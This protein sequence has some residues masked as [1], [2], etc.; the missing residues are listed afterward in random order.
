[1]LTAYND[2]FNN[3]HKGSEEWPGQGL[4]L[5]PAVTCYKMVGRLHDGRNLRI[6]FTPPRSTS[7]FPASA[8]GKRPPKLSLS[9]PGWQPPQ[10]VRGSGFPPPPGQICFRG[11]APL[12]LPGWVERK[13][14]LEG[15]NPDGAGN[16]WGSQAAWPEV[17]GCESRRRAQKPGEALDHLQ[18]SIQKG[19]RRAERDAERA[20]SAGASGPRR[21]SC[22]AQESP[23]EPPSGPPL[24]PCSCPRSPV[25]S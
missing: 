20:P 24:R 6:I 3:G 9:L 23:L 13:Q 19:G 8:T 25:R 10:G 1:M 21:Q 18:R 14:P 2:S 7:L 11:K 5:F 22:R 17:A 4:T 16:S 15:T 12:L